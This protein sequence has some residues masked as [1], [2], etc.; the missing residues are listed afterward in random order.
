MIDLTLVAY[1]HVSTD[2]CPTFSLETWKYF[3]ALR[4]Q[5]LR[6]SRLALF[7]GL[8]SLK[9]MPVLF[10][11]YSFLCLW[12]LPT[13]SGWTWSVWDPRSQTLLHPCALALVRVIKHLNYHQKPELSLVDFA[14]G[15]LKLL[16]FY[17]RWEEW[18][19]RVGPDGDRASLV[20]EYLFPQISSV[21]QLCGAHN[22]LS[23]RDDVT[24]IG[25]KTQVKPNRTWD[26]PRMLSPPN[27]A[28]SYELKNQM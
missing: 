23:H 26:A 15:H 20:S 2:L 7:P 22:V 21:E 6:A 16:L 13:A 11:H 18:H 3:L 12:I 14:W 17:Q 28:K 27:F 25:I 24:N 1:L 19:V 9:S 8:T 4:R 10:H 5:S